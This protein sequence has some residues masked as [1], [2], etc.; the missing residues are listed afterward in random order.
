MRL[1]GSS[2]GPAIPKSLFPIPIPCWTFFL[3]IMA[4]K[5][6]KPDKDQE[7]KEWLQS[8]YDAI[9]TIHPHKNVDKIMELFGVSKLVAK[10]IQDSW[11]SLTFNNKL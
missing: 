4:A 9:G 5:S 10:K 11:I 3:S 7:I 8:Q 1:I 2:Q 6:K